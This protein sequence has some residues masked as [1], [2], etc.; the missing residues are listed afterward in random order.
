MNPANNS[1][2]INSD[3]PIVSIS[4]YKKGKFSG[5]TVETVDCADVSIKSSHLK[6]L[7]NQKESKIDLQSLM[8]KRLNKF[9]NDN[10]VN[11][12]CLRSRIIAVKK[13]E[14]NFLVQG[15]EAV[16]SYIIGKGSQLLHSIIGSI[17]NVRRSVVESGGTVNFKFSQSKGRWCG[18]MFLDKETRN[19]LCFS[20]AINWIKCKSKGGD[21]FQDIYNGKHKEEIN[22]EEFEY[23]R[24]MQAPKKTKSQDDCFK[25]FLIINNLKLITGKFKFYQKERDIDNVPKIR[26]V[27]MIMDSEKQS[28]SISQL[29]ASAI[30]EDDNET[31]PVFKYIS[32]SSNGNTKDKIKSH[33]I[34]AMIQKNSVCFFDPNYGEFEFPDKKTFSLWFETHF[35]KD[36]VYGKNF[37]GL[38][39]P[40]DKEF[41]VQTI[42]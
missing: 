9:I 14:S 17:S 42:K 8:G 31:H 34:V 18:K 13:P 37:M 6:S 12:S 32:I 38:N 23:I 2:K 10:K 16:A 3:I 33:A 35:W 11:N 28:N 26:S 21:L 7:Y 39:T 20:L 36:A 4:E 40:L 19:G 5:R 27:N 15:Y 24:A 41:T 30:V 25:N 29:L 22:P 1:S